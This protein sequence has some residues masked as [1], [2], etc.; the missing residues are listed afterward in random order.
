MT[1]ASY[2]SRASA[3]RPRLFCLAGLLGIAALAHA[4]G[5]GA[6]GTGLVDLDGD[7]RISYEEF[8]HSVALRA[9][10]EMDADNS[11]TIS[12]GE[13]AAAKPGNGPAPLLV[14]VVDSNGDGQI[15]LDELKKPLADSAEMKQAFQ[16]LDKDHDGYLSGPELNGYDNGSHERIV[17]QISIQF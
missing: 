15:G 5:D 4:A 10:Q 12:R 16:N 11:G 8:V 17:P 6:P 7:N 13:A 14:P 3:W 1:Y 2:N 9:M